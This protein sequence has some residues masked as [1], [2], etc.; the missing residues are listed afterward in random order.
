[1][2]KQKTK[3]AAF[4]AAAAMAAFAAAS[5]DANTR[6][7]CKGPTPAAVHLTFARSC[8]NDRDQ[9]YSATQRGMRSF[10]VVTASPAITILASASE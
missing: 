8:S 2:K 10:R 1:M 7:N 4:A 9:L 5:A 6:A 3:L